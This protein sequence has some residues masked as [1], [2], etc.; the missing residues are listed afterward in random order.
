[1]A[2]RNGFVIAIVAAVGFGQGLPSSDLQA[3]RQPTWK[4]PGG[5]VVDFVAAPCRTIRYHE[6][7]FGSAL[8]FDGITKAERIEAFDYDGSVSRTIAGTWR[9]YWF[10]PEQ[11]GKKTELIL[12]KEKR[13]AY[14]DHERKIFETHVDANRKWPGRGGEGDDSLCSATKSNYSYLS[15]RLSDSV[16]AG[17]HVIGYRG[18]DSRGADYEVYFAPSIG[19]EVM[20]FQMVMRGFLG[21]ETAKEESVVDSYEIGPPS[22]QLFTVPNGYKQVTSILHPLTLP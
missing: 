21:W 18:R 15:E 12:R 2:T 3:P 11:V 7:S 6:Y 9:R 8:G 22:L 16:V 5:C 4:G 19:C 1:M 14:I 17:F 13:T 10:S 20:R